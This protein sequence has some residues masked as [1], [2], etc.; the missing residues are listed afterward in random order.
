MFRMCFLLKIWCYEL[1][2][3]S[4]NYPKNALFQTL[5]MAPKFKVQRVNFYANCF[6]VWY[7][8]KHFRWANEPSLALL[9]T[10][11]MKF[12]R[13]TMTK[14]LEPKKYIPKKKF[15]TLKSL[16]KNFIFCL[17]QGQGRV[18][19]GKDFNV[20]KDKFGMYFFC[21]NNFVMVHRMNFI[22]IVRSHPRLSSFAHHK[23][24][25]KCQTEKK[26]E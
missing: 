4:R 6:S 24:L 19:F 16:P 18:F 9:R 1:T 25:S 3:I 7:L 17:Y 12:I 20:K 21:S 5:F 2:S 11:K 15:F 14:L 8:D 10:I 23:C 13:W 26:L 22:L